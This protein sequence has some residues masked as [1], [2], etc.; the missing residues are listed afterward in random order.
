MVHCLTIPNVQSYSTQTIAYPRWWCIVAASTQLHLYLS[1]AMATR[2][3]SGNKPSALC[4]ELIDAL[5]DPR[6][7]EALGKAL[8]PVISKSVDD[9]VAPL[10]KQIQELKAENARLAKRCEAA[11]NANERFD[12]IAADH[13]RRLE[14][15]EVYSRSDYPNAPPPK[16]LPMLLSSTA[17]YPLS[18]RVTSRSNRMSY[19]FSMLPWE[20]RS[21]R[22][23]SRLRTA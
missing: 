12:K 11:E 20:S 23:I 10:V 15:M 19:S 8:A 7:V 6:L 18:A 9:A 17:L 3:K 22:R 13:F 21:C 14:D 2:S 1:P 5:L 4:E 16:R